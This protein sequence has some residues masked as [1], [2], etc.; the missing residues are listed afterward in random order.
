VDIFILFVI[1]QDGDRDYLCL[2][3]RPFFYIRNIVGSNLSSQVVSLY[4]CVC[5]CV[6]VCV[7]VCMYVQGVSEG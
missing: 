5:V 4:V 1:G 2:L 3:V 6:Y 7:Y